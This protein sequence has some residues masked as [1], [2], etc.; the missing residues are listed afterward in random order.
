[1]LLLRDAEIFAPQPIGRND[2][3]MGGAR[4]LAIGPALGRPPSD[5]PVEEL[6]LGGR[7]LVPGF[8]DAHVHLGGGG[9]EGGPHT[10]VPALHAGA[11]VHA[12]VTSCVA[13]LGT[14][15]TTRT[16]ADLVARVL[17]LRAEGL[18]AWCWTGSY[19]LPVRTLTGSVRGDLVFVDPVLGVGELAI[20]DHRS[21]QPTLDEFLRVAADVHVGGMMAD[22]AGVLHLHLGDGARGLELVRAA[23]RT[24]ELPASVFHPTHVNRSSR[25]LV[26]AQALAIE[27][28]CT[29]DVTAFPDDDL[30]D[31]TAAG[32]AI[33]AC[34]REGVPIEGITCSSDGGGC[35]PRF[36]GDGRMIGMGVGRPATL[37]EAWRRL[38]ALDIPPGD[39]LRPFTSSVARMLRLP[40][41]GRIAVGADADLVVLD[42]HQRPW[43][44]IARGELWLRD[45]TPVRTGTFEGA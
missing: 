27:H 39:A 41:K 2:V 42:E 37:V 7:W 10:R 16:M 6:D 13:L 11:L 12:G 9:G 14:D 43:H 29:I 21:S 32:D 22:K 1:M 26:E 24:S 3:L 17:G 36:D 23:L 4:I 33:A 18:S 40:S 38:L 8:V 5:W 20:S 34:I 15:G 25:L 19:E 35:L 45:G 30:G 44:V 28:G 31:A